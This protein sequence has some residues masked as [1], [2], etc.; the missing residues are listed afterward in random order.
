MSLLNCERDTHP[1]SDEL[2]VC[3]NSVGN[4]ARNVLLKKKHSPYHP[5]LPTEFLIA[6]TLNNPEAILFIY[7]LY[8]T[9][10]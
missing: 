5:P 6:C 3:P 1:T 2:N 9:V 8:L 4:G 10:L 7:I